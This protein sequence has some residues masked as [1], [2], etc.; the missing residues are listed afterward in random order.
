MAEEVG[1]AVEEDAADQGNKDILFGDLQ[2]SSVEL[3]RLFFLLCHGSVYCY[4]NFKSWAKCLRSFPMI[5]C[6]FLFDKN[7]FIF[8][9]V[10]GYNLMLTVLFYSLFTLR[11]TTKPSC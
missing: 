8:F 11:Y 1:G 2:F 4:L 9:W 5:S 10:S 3:K 6:H 7:K